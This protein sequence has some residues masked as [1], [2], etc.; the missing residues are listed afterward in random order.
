MVGEEIYDGDDRRNITKDKK[1]AGRQADFRLPD[2]LDLLV[3]GEEVVIY[4]DQRRCED[5]IL[6][7]H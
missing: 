5:I 7:V 4:V 1:A 2:I 3:E 6:V